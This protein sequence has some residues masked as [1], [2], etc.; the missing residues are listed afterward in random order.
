[1]PAVQRITI[2][3]DKMANKQGISLAYPTELHYAFSSFW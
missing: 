3:K 1:M 2:Y